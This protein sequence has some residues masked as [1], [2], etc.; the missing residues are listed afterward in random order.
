MFENGLFGGMSKI[1][2]GNGRFVVVDPDIMLHGGS[3]SK[4]DI[5]LALAEGEYSQVPF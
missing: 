1:A 2:Y 3:T 5:L 4:E